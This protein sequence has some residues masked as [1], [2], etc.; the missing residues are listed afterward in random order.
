MKNEFKK[1]FMVIAKCGHVGRKNYIPVKFA[2]VAESGKEAAKKVR[3]FPRV[4]HDHK[5]AILD[6]KCITLEEFLE[7]K[8]IND[9]DPYLKCHSRQEQNLI[10]NL[11]ERMVADLHNVKQAFDKQARKDRVAYKLRKFKI[12]EESSKKEDYCYAY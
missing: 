10:V 2:V 3:Q 11:A 7:I 1:Y 12:L 4:K 9:N 6:V 8:E 5:D